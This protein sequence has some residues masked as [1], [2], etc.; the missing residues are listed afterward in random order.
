M[1]TPL[2][3]LPSMALFAEVVRTRSFSEAAR[4]A[5]LAK[6]AVSKRIAQLEER[7]GVRLLMRSTRKLSLTQEGMRFYSHCAALV[8]AAD[9]AEEALSGASQVARG[10]LVVNA[11]VS[12]AQLQLAAPIAGFL[13]QHPEV[14]VE[15]NTDNHVVDPVEGG[16]DVAVRVARL[17]EGSFVARKLAED[18]LL[19]CAAPAYLARHGE[20]R[21]PEELARHNCLHYSM[22][23][24]ELEWRFHGDEGPY[25]V[26][27]TGSFSTNDGTL[28]AQAAVAGIGLAVVPSFIVARELADG[29]LVTVLPSH[30]RGRV[31][32]YAVVGARKQLALRTRLFIDHLAKHFARH[33]IGA[34]DLV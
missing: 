10:R 9:A 5:G 27:A 11:A 28:L 8:D 30:R 19:I 24:R 3:S 14:E 23:P 6:S 22:V 29:R 18:R 21:T 16:F 33:P 25:V 13:A 20:P 26:G 7:L 32:V 31:G 2:E 34:I 15:V 17:V 1:R 12:L 4:R